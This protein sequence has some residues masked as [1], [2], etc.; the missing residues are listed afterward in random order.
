[1]NL[2]KFLFLT[3]T[4][5]TLFACIYYIKF[6]YLRST[7]E[8]VIITPM[9]PNSQMTLSSP[10][11]TNGERIPDEYTCKGSNIN[12][13][14]EFAGVPETAQSLVLVVDD[15]D[16]PVG[17]WDHWLVF[18]IDPS[19]T[20]V[21]P[22]SVP[23]NGIQILNSFGK[24]VYGGPCPPVGQNHRYFFKLYAVDVMLD[25]EGIVDKPGLLSAIQA[26]TIAK[27]ELVGMYSR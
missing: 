27:S 17:T 23:V 9:E 20:G 10:S 7:D 4:V 3:I 24:E 2:A 18:N 14:L 26:H 5:G 19:T 1:M 12:P 16:A 8:P 25:P 21:A 11:F 22:D 13:P 6:V 15:P